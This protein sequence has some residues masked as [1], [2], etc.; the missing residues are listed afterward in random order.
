MKEAKE[1]I[2]SSHNS[3]WSDTLHHAF[4]I[5]EYWKEANSF[6]LNNID[7]EM[8]LQA[9]KNNIDPEVDIYQG[10]KERLLPSQIRKAKK[11]Q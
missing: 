2:Q 10:N 11:N 9:R 6:K 4:Q 3:W 1:K 8:I 7:G 5:H